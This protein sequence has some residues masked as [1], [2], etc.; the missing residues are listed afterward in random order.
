MG[1]AA[2]LADAGFILAPQFNGFVRVRGGDFLKFGR[3]VFLKDATASTA[4]AGCF[5]RPLSHD[6]SSRWSKLH[7]P[8]ILRYSTP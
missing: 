7:T 1:A 8:V 2:F 5:G 4:C 3:E 6:C